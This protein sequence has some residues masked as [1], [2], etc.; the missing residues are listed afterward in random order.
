M[1]CLSTSMSIMK[2]INKKIW[3]LQRS[4]ETAEFATKL[5]PHP[6]SLTSRACHGIFSSKNP[7]PRSS[8]RSMA[9]TTIS[10]W[11]NDQLL[12]LIGIC[13]WI[14]SQKTTNNSDSEDLFFQWSP[15]VVWCITSSCTSYQTPEVEQTSPKMDG[16]NGRRFEVFSTSREYTIEDF[17]QK[18]PRNT[19]WCFRNLAITT[20]WDVF[21]DL[22][23]MR[24][25]T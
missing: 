25:T 8:K 14:P 5:I 6:P 15:C 3:L 21:E 17:P 9:F 16:W 19:Q 10:P 18:N 24:S 13:S 12:S 4:E 20:T 23:T 22:E 2:K 7:H 1:I 11:E